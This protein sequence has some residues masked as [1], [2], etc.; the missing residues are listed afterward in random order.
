[1]SLY[2]IAQDHIIQDTLTSNTVHLSCLLQRFEAA[3]H[4][5]SGWHLLTEWRRVLA[6]LLTSIKDLMLLF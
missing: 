2:P 5:S 6:Q 4:V 1:M 3:H